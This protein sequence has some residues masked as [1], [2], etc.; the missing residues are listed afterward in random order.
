MQKLGIKDRTK[1]EGREY[2]EHETERCE[3]TVYIGK[4]EDFPNIAEAWSMTVN[5]FWF[6]DTYQAIARKALRY[7][8]Q[9]YKKPITRTPMRFFP[10]DEKTDQFGGPAWSPCKDVTHLKMTQLWYS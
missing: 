6:A 1:Y 4:S 7:L 10:P 9:I 3:V 5:E 2:E 8:C